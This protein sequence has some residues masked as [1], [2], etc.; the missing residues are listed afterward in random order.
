MARVIVRAYNAEGYHKDIAFLDE[1][2]VRMCYSKVKENEIADGGGV[3]V[4]IDPKDFPE[5]V[6]FQVIVK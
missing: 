1:Q 6:Y 2:Q 5:M 4:C 3:N